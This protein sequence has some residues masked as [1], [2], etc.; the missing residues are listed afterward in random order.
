[1]SRPAGLRD[2]ARCRRGHADALGAA[3]S[4]STSCAGGR[5]C[6]TCSTR[7]RRRSTAQSSWSGHGAERVTKKLTRT[8]PGSRSSSSSSTAARHRRRGA[9]RAHGL[10][11]RRRPHMASDDA[12]AGAARRHAAAAARHVA[13]PGGRTPPPTPPAR[14]L[15]ADVDDPTGYGR[16][17][18]EA[19]TTGCEHRRARRRDPRRAREIDEINTG[20]FC[21]RRSLLA[22]AAMAST[23]NAQGEYYLTDVVEVL[24]EAGHRVV[25]CRPSTP[26]RP[27]ASTT[28]P[29]SPTPKPSCGAAPTPGGSPGVSRW[30]IPASTYIDTTV[31]LAADVTLFPGTILQGRTVIGE[32][33]EIGPGTPA[34]GLHRRRAH[35]PR[36]HR[37]PHADIGDDCSGGSL[38]GARARHRISRPGRAPA[39]FYTGEP[40][41]R[42]TAD[43]RTP[44]TPVTRGPMELV[45]KKRLTSLAGRSNLA[46]G[47]GDRR[48]TSTWSSGDPNLVDFANGEIYCRLGENVRGADVFVIQTH[49]ATDDMSVND[50]IMEQLIMI[51]AARRA[52]AKRITAVIP[53]LRLRPPGP[54]GREPRA[55][56]RQARRQHV[57]GR[58]HQ[59]HDVGR[60]ALGPDPGLLR[61]SGRPPHR[62]AGHRR[63]HPEEPAATTWWSCRPTPA[64]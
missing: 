29:S 54:Q 20:I 64:A 52:S 42:S 62:H 60:P 10:R 53:L 37:R 26:T 30:S 25:R 11:R 12:R 28:A 47:R 3:R 14:V 33:V 17:W 23:A 59:P 34:G 4:L 21:F 63:L 6:S 1:M 38:R 58:R 15:T 13:G 46:A 43:R 24:A 22:R 44:T 41:Q 49:G 36:A 56:H 57:R 16:T 2:R 48:P 55:D 27:P 5:W 19:R 45:T 18:C 7:R 32:G 8:A 35:L 61:R 31:S 40:G 50:A 9:R 51:D 39:P